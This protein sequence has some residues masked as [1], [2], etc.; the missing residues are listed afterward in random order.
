MIT[1]LMN[2]SLFTPIQVLYFQSKGLTVEVIS[3]LNLVVPVTA[4]LMEIATGMIGDYIGRKYALLASVGLFALSS[5]ILI[6]SNN[7]ALFF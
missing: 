3:L 4:V 6:F 2:L 1:L 5:F 7:V